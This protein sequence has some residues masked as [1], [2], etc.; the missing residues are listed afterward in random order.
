[1]SLLDRAKLDLS[2]FFWSFAGA[3][4]V[5]LKQAMLTMYPEFVATYGDMAAVVAADIFEE[6]RGEAGVR[7]VHDVRLASPASV[8]QAERSA[9]WAVQPAFADD[10]DL[11]LT[12]LT[13]AAER[14]IRAPGRETIAG[15]SLEDPRAAGYK[16][17]TRAGSCE[18]CRML[19]DRGA[20]YMK[21]T[22]YF[23]AHDRCQCEVVPSWERDARPVGVAQ[24]RASERTSDMSEKQLAAHRARVRAYF[25]E[26]YRV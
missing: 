24:Y 8:E 18:F 13:G 19:S 2:E 11:A 16:R 23:A 21:G 20:V 4:P 5:E 15:N 22:A 14:L 26:H 1:M 3:D 17:L 9:R 12:Q 25:S 6:M 7:G 10:W